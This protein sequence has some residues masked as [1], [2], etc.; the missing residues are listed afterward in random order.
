MKQNLQLRLHQHLALTPQ[1][2]QSIRLLQLSTLELNQEIDQMLGDNPLLERAEE[3]ADAPPGTRDETGSQADER[4]ESAEQDSVY[5]E[6]AWGERPV[7]AASGDEEDDRV[8]QQVDPSSQGLRQH[9]K[10]QLS[11]MPLSRRD[12][13]LVTL[14]IEAL[15]DDGYLE[16]S[17]EEWA[18]M[19]PDELEI[20]P[21]ELSAALHLLQSFDPV[22]VGARDLAECLSLQL[23]AMPAGTAH[24]DMAK[25]LVRE[26]LPLLAAREYGKI[27]KLLSLESDRD[28]TAVRQLI[29]SL[30]PRPGS[31]FSSVEAQYV[32]PDVLVRKVKG[33]WQASLNPQAMPKLRI[34]EMYANILRQQRDSSAPLTGQLQEARWLIKNVQQ[35]FQ[36]IHRVAQAIVSRQRMFF[37]HGEVAMRPLT[38]R[39][40][41]DSVELHESTISRVTTQKYMMTPR[42]L[43]EFKYFFGSALNTD[44]G[45]AASSTAIKALIRQLVEAEDVLHPLSDNALS[46]MLGKQGFVVARRTVAKYREQLHVPP[47]NQRKTY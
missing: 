39:E 28:F 1:L 36:T 17:L 21:S 34:N 35:R 46:D 31:R 29:V 30:D 24:V 18:E 44:A 43:F 45:G 41:A 6:L 19:L 2:Q 11:L 23:A 5:D 15:D 47:A 16:G 12:Q 42:G 22:G 7:S 27:K 9:L 20:D 4:P 10:E 37:E 8:F 32:V 14:L 40:I 25:A 3:P 33:E 26:H 38:L 13:Q